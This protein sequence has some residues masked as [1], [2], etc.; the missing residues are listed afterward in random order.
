VA[1]FGKAGGDDDG[2]LDAAAAA[3]L[4]DL[5]TVCGRVTITAISTRALISSIDL[6]A[7]HAL[8]RLVLRC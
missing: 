4:D 8:D 1:G 5:G 3:L 2:V 7:R 6:Y